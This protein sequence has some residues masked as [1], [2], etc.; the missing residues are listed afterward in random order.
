MRGISKKYLIE[1]NDLLN[2][3]VII[4]EAQNMVYKEVISNFGLKKILETKKEL[5]KLSIII[6]DIY[7]I[8]NLK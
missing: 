4:S 7:T 5:D 3:R 8:K 2:R 6:K 1:Q